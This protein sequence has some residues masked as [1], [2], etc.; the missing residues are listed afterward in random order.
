MYGATETT[1]ESVTR[2]A[3]SYAAFRRGLDRLLAAGV[4][5]RLKAMALRANVHELP[6]MAAFCRART[7][8]RYRFDPLLHMRFDG[9]PRRNAEIRAQRLSPEEVVSV[10]QA[11]A[12]RAEAL[13]KDCRDRQADGP[14][15]GECD[16]LFHCG[17]GAGSF[18]VSSDGLFRLCSSLWHPECVYDL[19]GGTLVEAWNDHVPKVLARSSRDAEFLGKCR[20]C[21]IVNLCLWCPAHAHLET[22]RLDAWCGEFCKVAHAR[23]AAVRANA[24]GPAAVR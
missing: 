13:R 10:E 1:Y 11:D 15:R 18:A 21:P 4:R 16:G 14:A 19:R 8:D 17:A 3:G 9:D 23:A 12:E 6:E 24:A 22:G 2:R 5:V 7:R 20:R